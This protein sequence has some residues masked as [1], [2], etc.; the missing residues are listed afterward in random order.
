MKY[1]I[2]I[3]QYGKHKRVNMERCKG[4]QNK[5]GPK[6]QLKLEPTLHRYVDTPQAKDELPN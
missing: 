3:N 4:T 5:S 6:A 1:D 2:E